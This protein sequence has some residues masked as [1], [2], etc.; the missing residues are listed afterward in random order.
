MGIARKLMLLC[1]MA[2]TAMAMAAS[3]ASAQETAVEFENENG[4]KCGTT[5]NTGCKI[6]ATGESHITNTSTGEEI[7][8][9]Q[10]TFEGSIHHKTDATGYAG[11]IT[12][13]HPKNHPINNP[14]LCTVGECASDE[15]EW[16]IFDPGETAPNTGHMWVDFCLKSSGIDVHCTA[17]VKVTEVTPHA[18]QFSTNQ[19]CAFGTRR[20]EGTWNQVI[21]AAHPAFEVDH[22]PDS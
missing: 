22:T 18:H 12:G 11:H 6:K 10:D 4:T 5:E 7:S 16:D 14:P 20:V 1:A 3:T 21:D 2:I 13:W 17:E 8:S 9:C 15:T 19:L